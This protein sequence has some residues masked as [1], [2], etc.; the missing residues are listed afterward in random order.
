LLVE[1]VGQYAKPIITDWNGDGRKDLICGNE[2]GNVYLFQ[3]GTETIGSGTYVPKFLPSEKIKVSGADIDI[4]AFASPFVCDWN[5]DSGK[6][7]IVGEDYGNIRL[8]INT[9]HSPSEPPVFNAS[10]YVDGN[11]EPIDIGGY[12]KPQVIDWNNDGKKDIIVGEE[13]GQVAL[14]LNSG[15]DEDPLFTGEFFFVEKSGTTTLEIKLKSASPYPCDWNNDYK[16]DLIAG[17]EYG[18]VWVF[19][20]SATNDAPIFNKGTYAVQ[21]GNLPIDV[22]YD[23]TPCVIDYNNDGKKDLLIGDR[24]GN[25]RLFSNTNTDEAPL[26]SEPTTIQSGVG[27][28]ASPFVI[29]YNKDGKKDLLVGVEDGTIWLFINSGT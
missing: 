1:D 2:T 18:Y 21:S 15:R 27:N 10:Q 29:D 17:D 13:F 20:N 8:F 6:D 5:N 26:F 14:F 7:L 4:G 22:G 28:N 16:K 25:I 11:P 9:S 23:A 19:I 3:R 24:Y 12:S